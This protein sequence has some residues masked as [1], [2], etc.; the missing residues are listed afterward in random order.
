MKALLFSLCCLLSFSAYAQT[1]TS[2]DDFSYDENPVVQTRT[3]YPKYRGFFLGLGPRFLDTDPGE[4][5][6][7]FVDDSPSMDNFNSVFTVKDGYTPIGIQ[8]G[9]K[10]GRYQGISQDV[11][12]DVSTGANGVLAF[13]YS[14]GYNIKTQIKGNTLLI[15]PAVQG[16]F[17][18]TIFGL[19]EIQNNAAYIQIDDKQYFERELDVELR[20]QNV[21]LAAKVD[22][23]YKILSRVDLFLKIAYDF[24]SENTNPSLRLSVPDR[25]RTD[26]SPGDSSLDIDSSNPNL[27]YNG[28]KLIN[29][30]YNPGG[31]RLTVGA[32]YLWNRR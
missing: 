10:W 6:T 16:L 18:N 2:T 3:E 7:N 4:I 22:L 20:S 17:S 13:G 23:H 30:P 28:E 31:L 24:S 19:G 25:L 15:R 11:L 32:S 8:F 14:I 27:T 5:T 26:N 1:T 9:Y 12:F 21:N 29:L